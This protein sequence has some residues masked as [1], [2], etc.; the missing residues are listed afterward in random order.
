MCLAYPIR[1]LV[2][3]LIKE[4]NECYASEILLQL[5]RYALANLR[6]IL[7][8]RCRVSQRLDL[9]CSGFP[10]EENTMR[11][12]LVR[13]GVGIA[14]GVGVLLLVSGLAGALPS[15]KNQTSQA[16]FA[17]RSY[18]KEDALG[19][20]NRDRLRICVQSLTAGVNDDTI[21]EALLGLLPQLRTHPS[22]KRSGLDAKPYSVEVGCPG[23]PLIDRTGYKLKEITPDLLVAEA[24]PY[25]LF[26]YVAASDR[27]KAAGFDGWTEPRLLQREVQPNEAPLSYASGVT[28]ELYV[29]PEELSNPAPLIRALKIVLKLGPVETP[30][31]L[32]AGMRAHEAAKQKADAFATKAARG[33]VQVRVVAAQEPVLLRDATSM[34]AAGI[35]LTSGTVL[36]QLS[37]DRDGSPVGTRWIEVRDAQGRYGFVRAEQVVPLS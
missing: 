27:L 35:E 37:P 29:T 7:S 28:S 20:T 17:Q 25:R 26:V 36:T 10:V 12:I 22:W 5:Y 6:H 18:P 23:T 24:S 14:A 34:R 31:E 32:E 9:Q 19:A 30:E 13:V 33:P 16:P 4:A 11:G 21:R 8:E 15:A 1:L 2:I 3:V